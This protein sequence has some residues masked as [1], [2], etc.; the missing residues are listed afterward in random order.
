MGI[1]SDKHYNLSFSPN[2]TYPKPIYFT[3]ATCCM[4]NI[5]SRL[6]FYLAVFHQKYDICVFLL[7]KYNI[8]TKQFTTPK[9]NWNSPW[10][11][12]PPSSSVWTSVNSCLLKETQIRIWMFLA[13]LNQRGNV[14]PCLHLPSV[15]EQSSFL[16]FILWSLNSTKLD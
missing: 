3:Y 8:P 16:H 10:T 6:L 12:D 14:H 4:H 7:N 2:T 11:H 15:Q 1:K 13:L 9:M 5:Y